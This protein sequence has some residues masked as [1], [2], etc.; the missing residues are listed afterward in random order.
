MNN[1]RYIFFI[2]VLSLFIFT[3][4]NPAFARID[5]FLPRQ[6]GTTDIWRITHDPVM[7]DWANYHNTDAWRPECN[8]PR[9][10]IHTYIL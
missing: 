8:K 2:F 7:R 5:R 1:Q 4:L 3:C 10:R 6:G 9:F